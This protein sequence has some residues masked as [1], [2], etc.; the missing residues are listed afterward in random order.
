MIYLYQQVMDSDA[1]MVVCPT[2]CDEEITEGSLHEKLVCFLPPG[3]IRKHFDAMG[4]VDR[5]VP[6]TSIVYYVRDDDWVGK[7]VVDFPVSPEMTFTQYRMGVFELL[8]I[9]CQMNPDS[10][11][12]PCPMPGV[13]F[14]EDCQELTWRIAEEVVLRETDCAVELCTDEEE[15]M[16]LEEVTQK[17][18]VV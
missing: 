3:Y 12:V 18:V 14:S 17:V 10:I 13:P 4:G 9:A 5:V 6:G 16:V 15:V 1:D 8:R 7:W 11:A 2:R